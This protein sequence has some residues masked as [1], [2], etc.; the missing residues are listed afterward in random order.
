MAKI[1]SVNDRLFR[2]F[3]T[4]HYNPIA[5][6]TVKVGHFCNFGNRLQLR[7]HRV[8]FVVLDYY[9][10]VSTAVTLHLHRPSYYDDPDR[11][12]AAIAAVGRRPRSHSGMYRL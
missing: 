7:I 1:T 8:D 10:E 3:I 2:L 11:P 12:V 9:E 4:D 6:G 5:F